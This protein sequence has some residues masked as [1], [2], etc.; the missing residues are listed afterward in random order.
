MKK[1]YKIAFDIPEPL[2]LSFL[3]K[4]LTVSGIIG[5]TQGVNKASKPPKN[6]NPKMLNKEFPLFSVSIAEF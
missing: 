1:P 3:V 5:K 2:L 6:P 4:K